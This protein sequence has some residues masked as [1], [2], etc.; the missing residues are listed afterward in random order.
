MLGFVSALTVSVLDKVG[1]WASMVLSGKNL[2][3]WYFSIFILE[4][5]GAGAL[6]PEHREGCSNKSQSWPGEG[7][8]I[9]RFN[10]AEQC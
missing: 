4:I 7:I 10:P 3:K 2:K 5:P 6:P 1:S 9:P 8:H